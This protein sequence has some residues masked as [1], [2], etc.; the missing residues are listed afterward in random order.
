VIRLNTYQKEQLDALDQIQSTLME[1]STKTKDRLAIDLRLY[2][3]F[4]K[5]VDRYLNDHLSS[6]CTQACFNSQTSACCSKDGII[7]FWADMVINACSCTHDELDRLIS[8]VKNPY[9][10]RKCVYLGPEGCLW[11]VRPLVCAMFVC[12]QLQVDVIR[13]DS[14]LLKTWEKYRQRAK[15]F[16]W[17]DKPVL[18]DR[19]EEMFM[20]L[21]CQSPL[22]YIN[23][24]PGLMKI[25]R[26]ARL[27]K[28]SGFSAR[29]P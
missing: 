5:E 11:T 13:Q 12:D 14:K 24:S 4:R 20:A 16:R 3:D 1:M 28:G 10:S 17:P 23:S 18:F 2:L 21:G 29:R 22:M 25:K 26:K 27:T 9:Y 15:G 19:L 7:T 8:A 6:Y